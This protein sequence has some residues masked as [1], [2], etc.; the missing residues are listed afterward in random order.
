MALKKW[1]KEI[2]NHYKSKGSRLPFSYST[3]KGDSIWF[4]PGQALHKNWRL[5]NSPAAGTPIVTPV[6]SRKEALSIA[7]KY[8]RSH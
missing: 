3:E 6:K 8:M 5:V 4:A 7:K 1:K 2:C